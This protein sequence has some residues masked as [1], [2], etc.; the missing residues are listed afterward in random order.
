VR[1]HN[2]VFRT[3]NRIRPVKRKLLQNLSGRARAH[4]AQLAR[5]GRAGTKQSP[6]FSTRSRKK[7]GEVQ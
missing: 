3:L 7:Y 5:Q 2:A 6:A 4:M 1:L